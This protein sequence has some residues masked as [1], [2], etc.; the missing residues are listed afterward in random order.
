GSLRSLRAAQDLSNLP[1]VGRSR[2]Q[3]A[4][5]RS[6]GAG[7]FLF[8]HAGPD[9]SAVGVLPV[10]QYR[11]PQCVRPGAGTY[12]LT[13]HGAWRLLLAR[14]LGD[15]RRSNYGNLRARARILLRRPEGVSVPGLS[16]PDDADQHGETPQQ[17]EHAVLENDQGRLRSFRGD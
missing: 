11:L 10:I 7:R 15:D 5:G 8:D 12:R 16:V 13:A 9:E 14:L 17:S 1:L 6:P 4:R 2:T 3:G